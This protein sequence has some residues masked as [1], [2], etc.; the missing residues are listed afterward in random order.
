MAEQTSAASNAPGG[1]AG[2]DNN[3]ASAASGTTG[4]TGTTDDR[5]LLA[6]A[7]D[8]GGDNGGESG[9]A[10][11]GFPE[12]WRE[13]LAG[14]DKAAL[15]RL[16][17]FAGPGDLFKS[18][19]E[20]EKRLSTRPTAPSLPEGATPEEVAAYRKAIGVPDAPEGYG[21]KF[22]D[23]L[24]PSDGDNAALA[25]FQKEMH[26]AHVPPGAAKAA[27]EFYQKRMTDGRA[28][29]AEAAEAATLE[30]MAELRGEWK[31]REYGR[32][33]KI[34]DEFLTK[35]F[36]EDQTQLKAVNEILQLR[37]PNGVQVMH[38]APFMKGLVSMAR[39][40]ADDD[41]LIGSLDGAGGGTSVD[42]EYQALIK[43]SA[44]PGGK[45]S[46]PEWT[47]LQEL[48]AAR[49]NREQKAGRSRAG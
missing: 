3:A 4:T 42:D 22:A 39:S 19:R 30:N 6:G 36:G 43:K 31:G 11:A 33:M 37:L 24:K 46:E 16:K 44:A 48:S 35:H 45:L 20:A 18:Y 2:G 29:M 26:A 12:N 1:N 32:N 21:F 27:F 8:D 34:A 49:V 7:G 25:E 41:V 15:D 23:E 10:P 14:D 9:A 28:A 13:S 40:Y 5:T 38:Y 17:R 47:R